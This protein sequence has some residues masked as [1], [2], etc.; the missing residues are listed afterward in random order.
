MTGN[1]HPLDV[2]RLAATRAHLYM[3]RWALGTVS[4]RCSFSLGPFEGKRGKRRPG[5]ST[6]SFGV[7]GT[8]KPLE[9]SRGQD[10]EARLSCPV[11]SRCPASAAQNH[12]LPRGGLAGKLCAEP[13]FPAFQKLM[14]RINMPQAH[15]HL[16]V[17][18]SPGVPNASPAASGHATNDPQ[19][20]LHDPKPAHHHTTV[21]PAS[22]QHHPTVCPGPAPALLQLSATAAA[23]KVSIWMVAQSRALGPMLSGDQGT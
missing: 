17:H 8:L 2:R 6:K 15:P 11:P 18:P 12:T 1:S 13:R 4:S 7:F 19:L 22:G 3:H 21:P 14:E 16:T 10:W 9:T 20:L 23:A 5:L